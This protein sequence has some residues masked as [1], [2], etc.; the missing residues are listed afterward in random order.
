VRDI[1]PAKPEVASGLTGRIA[2]FWTRN[3]NAE[4]IMGRT[5]SRHERG[6]EDYFNDLETQRFRSHRHLPAW[7]ELMQP[8]AHVLEVGCGIGLD[9]ARMARRGMRVTA[10]DLTVV[11]ARTAS[12]R[13]RAHGWDA[14][15]LC[16]NGEQLPFPDA[17]FDYVYSFGVMHHAS[18]TQRCVDEA[19][20][21]LRP[22]GQALIMLYH[23][24]SLNE[25]VHRLTKVPFEERDELCPVVRRFT[26]REVR[27]MFT[28][29]QS[30]EV[31]ADFVYGEGYGA[32]FRLT[33]G[34]LYRAMSRLAGWHLM[35]R[36]VR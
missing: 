14:R 8:G 35:I 10:M 2:D 12:S 19:R 28:G 27:A 6:S 11:G 17:V 31:R 1:E 15:Y 24:H 3:V 20:R 36:A 33:P 23:R 13:A 4:R 30:T 25:L 5:V 16:A 21:V 7:I 34:L 26:R 29:F 32:V 18:D 9:S 22:G